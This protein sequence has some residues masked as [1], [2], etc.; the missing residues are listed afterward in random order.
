MVLDNPSTLQADA[1]SAL[2]Y[3]G[4][5]GETTLRRLHAEGA[6]REPFAK[7]LLDRIARE[8]FRRPGS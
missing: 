5:P 7:A 2:T 8:G 4:Q 1:I 6:V 3:M